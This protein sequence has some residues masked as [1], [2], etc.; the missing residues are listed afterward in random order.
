M[1]DSWDIFFSNTDV[2]WCP[3]TECFMS[4]MGN[5]GDDDIVANGNVW[6]DANLLDIFGATNNP[7]GYDFNF[8][9]TCT[10]GQQIVHTDGFQFKQIKDCTNALTSVTGLTTNLVFNPDVA[11]AQFPETDTLEEFFNN[12]EP[13]ECPISNCWVVEGGSIISSWV[14]GSIDSTSPFFLHLKLNDPAGYFGDTKSVVCTN[15]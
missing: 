2:T 9:V 8:C 1:T 5:C 11:T 4:T 12:Q 13:V 15:G 10:N 7:S 6:R 14:K 3:V